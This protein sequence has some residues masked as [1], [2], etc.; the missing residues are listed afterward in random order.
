MASMVCIGEPIS[1]LRLERFALDASDA[2]VGEH[3]AA[4]AA[5]RQC[6]D[7]IRGDVVA[8]PVLHVPE[9]RTWRW[10][11]LPAF[12]AL[13]G[14]A[15]ILFVLRPRDP[16]EDGVAHVKG[17][18]EVVVDVVRERA[19]SVRSDVRTFAP[20]D[21]FKVVVTCPPTH[22]VSLE[23]GVRE[24]GTE[25]VD[26]PLAPARIVCGNRIVLPGAFELTEARPHRVCVRIEDRASACLTLAPE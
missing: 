16:D 8:L 21:R 24:S 5:C 19:G 3:V 18:G 1:W 6:L 11:A 22:E 25:R 9:R 10:F 2:G 7:E 17:V 15:L 12:A 4:C 20:G 26:H 14:A 23:V 13:A